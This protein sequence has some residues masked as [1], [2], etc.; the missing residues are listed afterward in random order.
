M[1]DG[2]S[3]LEK[4]YPTAEATDP[5]AYYQYFYDTASNVKQGKAW[6]SAS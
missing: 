5:N 1:Y 3:R 6:G 2:M 4:L